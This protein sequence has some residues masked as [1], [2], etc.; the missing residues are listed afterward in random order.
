MI[1]PIKAV[2]QELDLAQDMKCDE[3]SEKW[4]TKG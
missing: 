4:Q 2:E 3:S 1:A